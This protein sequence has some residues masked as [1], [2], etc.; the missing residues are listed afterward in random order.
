MNLILSVIFRIHGIAKDIKNFVNMKT[1]KDSKINLITS[2]HSFSFFNPLPL[3]L[4]PTLFFVFCFLFLIGCAT[5]PKNS[6]ISINPPSSQTVPHIQNVPGIT[7]VIVKN[8]T[9]WSI[10]R[11][12]GVD[13]DELLRANNISE[14]ETLNI[15]QPIFI[16]NAKNNGVIQKAETDNFIWPVKGKVTSTFSEKIGNI[17]NKGLNISLHNDTEIM[18]SRS[19]KVVFTDPGFKGYGRTLIIEHKNEFFTVYTL[20]SEILVKPGDYVTQG[21]P[22]ARLKNGILHFEIRKGHKPKN[23]YYYLPA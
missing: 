17:V 13:I 18:A 16:P 19:G 2:N 22:V 1:F 21:A 10:S 5:T 4:N 11:T 14:T 3:T 15:G 8:E 20:L 6:S 7:H 9:L 23:P 12:Y